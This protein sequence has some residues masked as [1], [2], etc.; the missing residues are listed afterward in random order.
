MTFEDFVRS[1]LPALL[2]FA[3]VLCVDAGTAEDVVQDVLG[4]AQSRWDVIADMTAPTAYVRRMI[5]NEYLSWRRKWS[6]ITPVSMVPDRVVIDP[7]D[8]ASD[9]AC[10]VAEIARLPRRQRTVITMRYFLG[11]TDVE[12]AEDLGCSAGTVR[13]HLSRALHSLRVQIE[14]GEADDRVTH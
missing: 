6:R 10:L 8:A 1:E 9:R 7:A 3:K 5:V 14:I 11:L 13:S 12:I 2:R 4:R